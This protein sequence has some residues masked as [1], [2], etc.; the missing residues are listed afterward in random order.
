MAGKDDLI[1]YGGLALG[2]YFLYKFSKPLDT[3][4]GVADTAAGAVGDVLDFSIDT[5]KDV[6]DVVKNAP[7]AVA[8]SATYAARLTTTAFDNT[9][10]TGELAVDKTLNFIKRDNKKSTLDRYQQSFSNE[11]Y[12]G[13]SQVRS[14]LLYDNSENIVGSYNNELK[15]SLNAEATRQVEAQQKKNPVVVA[16]TSISN[17]KSIPKASSSDAIA[18]ASL[19]N[20]VTAVN[21]AVSKLIKDKKIKISKTK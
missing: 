11:K 12:I 10:N 20:A 13:N 7:E 2:A 17:I 18:K 15:Q 3:I 19:N 1:L 16:M 21:A 8:A 4:A 9:R 5:T 6:V 14:V